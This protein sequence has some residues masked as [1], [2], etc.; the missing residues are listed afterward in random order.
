MDWLLQEQSTLTRCS[1]TFSLTAAATITCSPAVAPSTPVPLQ[2]RRLS[3]LTVFPGLSVRVLTSAST[4]SAAPQSP[5]HGCNRIYPELELR[6]PQSSTSPKSS[7][8][9]S[10]LFPS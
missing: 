1:S 3:I 8:R 4:S 9:T 6:K 5:G 7:E 10:L 2:P